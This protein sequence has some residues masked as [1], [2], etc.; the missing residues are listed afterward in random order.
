LIDCIAEKHQHLAGN[1]TARGATQ[2]CLV[3]L[4]VAA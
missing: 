1:I 3:S 4:K 2:K